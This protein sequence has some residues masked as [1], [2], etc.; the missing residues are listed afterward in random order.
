MFVFSSDFLF[1]FFLIFLLLLF[2]SRKSRCFY[3]A[4]LF[5]FLLLFFLTPHQSIFSLLL[6][7]F[8]QKIKI[9]QNI[10]RKRLCRACFSSFLFLAPTTQLSTLLF[11]HKM[12]KI[13]NLL[14]FPFFKNKNRKRKERFLKAKDKNLLYSKFLR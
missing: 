3:K 11:C 9:R 14:L 4:F 8:F 1:Y 6:C 2:S 10:F 13:K 7:H 12:K 5:I